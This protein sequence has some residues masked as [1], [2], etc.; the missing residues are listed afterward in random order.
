M[1][2]GIGNRFFNRQ[3][4]LRAF[5]YYNTLSKGTRQLKNSALISLFFDYSVA[6]F[7]S[8]TSS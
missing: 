2:T 7:D 1:T 8:A 4:F 3:H 6:N 5:F